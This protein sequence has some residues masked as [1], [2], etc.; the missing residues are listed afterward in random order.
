MGLDES[1]LC[2]LQSDKSRLRVAGLLLLSPA[3]YKAYN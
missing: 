1:D 2:D 3:R